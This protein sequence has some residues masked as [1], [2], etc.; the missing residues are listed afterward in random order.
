MKTK[1]NRNSGRK[2][3][4]PGRPRPQRGTTKPEP[5]QSGRLK[6]ALADARC[7][8]IGSTM[9]RT[10]TTHAGKT[11]TCVCE[12]TPQ[13]FLY[14]GDLYDSPTA[15]ATKFARGIMG[16]AAGS[17]RAG[18]Q[19]FLPKSEVPANN[20]LTSRALQERRAKM[21]GGTLG[22]RKASKRASVERTAAS[23]AP[24]LDAT[25]RAVDRAS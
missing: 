22:K 19:F 11:V 17:R 24:A 15:V 20:R 8:P 7:P 21:R 4:H 6:A 1:N 16:Q 2:V 10:V 5:R 13:G 3:R 23:S 9:T 18:F 25:D 14:E 12:V